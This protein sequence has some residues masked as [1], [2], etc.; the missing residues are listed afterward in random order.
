[1]LRFLI[2]STFLLFSARVNIAQSSQD[3]FSNIQPYWSPNGEYIAFVSSISGNFEVYVVDL[4]TYDIQNMSHHPADDYYP[5]WSPDG[6]YIAYFS[7]RES[8]RI[9]DMS[10]EEDENQLPINSARDGDLPSWSPNSR[11]IIYHSSEDGDFEIYSRRYDGENLRKLTSN[12]AT[13]VY[14]FYS[15]DGEKIVFLSKRDG[16]MEIYVMN[17]DGSHQTRLTYTSWAY[18]INPTWSP[19]GKKIA[20]ASNRNKNFDI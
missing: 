1:M 8:E 11:Y 20:F 6:D 18:E 19:N 4:D 13:D 2:A 3:S 15:P 7:E 12:G 10:F 17:K 14:P 16:N 9:Y 5:A